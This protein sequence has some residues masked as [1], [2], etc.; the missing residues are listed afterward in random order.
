MTDRQ[1][2]AKREAQTPST[3]EGQEAQKAL[4]ADTERIYVPD[5]DIRE[6]S[7]CV[8][9]DANMPGVDQESVDVSV[10]NGVLT[11]EGRARIDGPQGYELVG[12][13]Y[14]VGRYRRDFTLSDAVDAAGIKA[15]VRQGVLE[16]TLPKRENVKTRKIRIET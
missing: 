12:Q 2:V 4:A 14:G 9:M 13:E 6:D 11:I 10:E 15:R 5:V 1:Q 8:H 16:V 7:E 3:W